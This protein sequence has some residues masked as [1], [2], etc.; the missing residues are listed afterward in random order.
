MRVALALAIVVACNKESSTPGAQEKLAKRTV[1]T[2]AAEAFPQW[3]MRHPDKACPDR[4]ADLDEYMQ[5]ASAVD[6]WGHPYEML[7]GKNLPPGARG[8]I[9][10]RSVGKDGVAGTADDINSWP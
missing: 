7:C 5:G 9:A 4:L 2:Y 6:P 1:D 3:A 10:V 8:G